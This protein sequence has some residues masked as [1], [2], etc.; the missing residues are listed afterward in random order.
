MRFAVTVTLGVVLGV[1]GC[2]ALEPLITT[3]RI[4]KFAQVQP[5]PWVKPFHSPPMSPAVPLQP[6]VKVSH[7]AAQTAAVA[8]HAPLQ[9]AFKV[10]DIVAQPIAV[11]GQPQVRIERSQSQAPGGEE[12]QTKAMNV[13][14]KTPYAKVHFGL[15]VL[16]AGAGIAALLYS[17]NKRARRVRQS[18]VMS[19]SEWEGTEREATTSGNLLAN[20]PARAG[21]VQMQFTSNKDMQYKMDAKAGEVADVPFE[22]R[23]S[24][25]NVVTVSGGVFILFSLGSFL[26]NS[27]QS[28]LVQTLGFVY[29]IPALVGG[30]ALKYAE[31]PPVPLDSTPEAEAARTSKGTTIQQ[32]IVS[33]AT[34][35]TYGDAH[36]EDPLKALKLAPS[37]MGPPTLLRMKES[38]TE[39]GQYSL[40]MRF[41]SP[42]TPWSVWQDRGPRYSRFFGPNIRAVLKKYDSQLRQVELS[43]ITCPEGEDDKPLVEKEDGTLSPLLTRMEQEKLAAAKKESTDATA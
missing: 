7:I 30:L 13:S 15:G 11:A 32:K 40:T 21:P 35:F 28:N 6:A 3:Q 31:L 8:G 34:R 27:G 9:P 19:I 17:M 42:N 36:M 25:G 22:V 24:I 26:L 14:Q 2:L 16:G 29:S 4:G 41:S 12:Q 1:I 37:G 33:D 23:F 43:L 18:P 10:S 39:S 20:T 38:L 5:Q